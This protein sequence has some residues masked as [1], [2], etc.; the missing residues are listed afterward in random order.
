MGMFPHN[1]ISDVMKTLDVMVV[2]SFWYETF[3]FSALEAVAYGVPVLVSN[4][5]GSKDVLRNISMPHEFKPD[6]REL[7]ELL[8]NYISKPELLDK[9]QKEQQRLTPTFSMKEHVKQ[10]LKELV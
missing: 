10:L 9:L 7:S 4:R 8:E 5:A 6:P 1:A 3:G 2:P